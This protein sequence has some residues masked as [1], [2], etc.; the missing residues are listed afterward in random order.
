M[1][2]DGIKA[3]V[4]VTYLGCSDDQVTYGGHS[5]P[6][7]LFIVGNQYIV[8]DINISSWY[9]DIYFD[10]IDGGFNS[11]CFEPVT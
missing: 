4:A 10:G 2:I 6:R 9:S 8:S 3:G 5:D 1:E 7:G 11:V